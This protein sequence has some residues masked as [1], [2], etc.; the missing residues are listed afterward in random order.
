MGF[1]TCSSGSKSNEGDKNQHPAVG[2]KPVSP[3]M[4]L[5][6]AMRSRAAAKRPD[7]GNKMP[8]PM[9]ESMRRHVLACNLK[10]RKPFKPLKP[11]KNQ[12][13]DRANRTKNRGRKRAA[14]A[15]RK[16]KPIRGPV[17][18]YGGVKKHRR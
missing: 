3:V 4:P 7:V 12:K 16:D 11:R 5:R 8:R 15:I 18:V 9:S 2:S 1:L 13:D 10:A 14:V 6:S 17:P